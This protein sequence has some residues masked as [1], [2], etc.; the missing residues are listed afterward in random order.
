VF[1]L[2]RNSIGFPLALRFASSAEL[3]SLFKKLYSVT[4]V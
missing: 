1:R 4:P 2:P 3:Y